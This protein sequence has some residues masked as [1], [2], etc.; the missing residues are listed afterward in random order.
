MAGPF[1]FIQKVGENCTMIHYMK[2]KPEPF[3]Q[4]ACGNKTFELRLN[5]EKR[6]LLKVGD[7]IVFANTTDPSL[8]IVTQILNIYHFADFADL[9]KELPLDKCGYLPEELENASPVDMT[10]YYG[11]EA[12]EK[13]GVLGIEI[14]LAG[15]D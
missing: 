12:Q 5:D 13:Y 7:Q 4:I 3:D 6:Q 10:A 14:R 15:K 1:I 2:L 11:I 9:Y 8:K